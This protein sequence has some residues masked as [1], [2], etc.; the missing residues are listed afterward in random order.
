MADIT[1]FRMREIL[2]RGKRMRRVKENHLLI[3]LF[4]ACTALMGGIASTMTIVTD[5]IPQSSLVV[6]AYGTVLLHTNAGAYVLVGLL[7][8][9]A[10]V[11]TTA[12]C[13]RA[14]HKNNDK[15]KGEPT[16]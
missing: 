14:R 1:D 7:A 12:L 11:A 15:N 16:K 6:G 5:T 10:G 8:F 2:R 9:V 4:C 3:G 13:L